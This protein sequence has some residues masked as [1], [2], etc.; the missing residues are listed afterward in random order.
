MLQ[1]H[2]ITPPPELVQRLRSEAPYAIS[3]TRVTRE[4]HLIAAAYR[5]GADA[6]LDAVMSW[7]RDQTFGRQPQW[8]ALRDAMRPK[9]QSLAEEAQRILVENSRTFGGR[10]EFDLED[11]NTIC[12]DLK[13][14]QE[15]E[16]NG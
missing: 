4:R 1:Q 3:D 9:P 8:L 2:P 10:V 5:A 7:L 12:R 16:N 6:Q 11:V 13:R 15:L 14:L